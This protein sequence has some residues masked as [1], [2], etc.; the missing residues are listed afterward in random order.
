MK[1]SFL[2]QIVLVVLVAGMW[3]VG[4]APAV[5]LP[6]T[7]DD[8][9]AAKF[10]EQALQA[11]Q[12][13]NT[14]LRRQLLQEA[15]QQDPNHA[16]ARWHAGYVWMDQ[17][18][19]TLDEVARRWKGEPALAQYQQLRKQVLDG[20]LASHL[21]LAR[22]CQK[23]SLEAEA[24]AHWMNVL[25]QAPDNREAATALKLQPFHGVLVPADRLEEAKA[26]WSR[27][28]AEQRRWAKRRTE[29]L[30]RW[31]P[32]LRKWLAA[33][34]EKDSAGLRERIDDS[35]TALC[36]QEVVDASA[37]S[38]AL[39]EL[40]FTKI[41]QERGEAAREQLERVTLELVGVLRTIRTE[42]STVSLAR[43]AVDYP[44]E[45]VRQAATEALKERPQQ[46]VVPVLISGMQVP[47]EVSV[48]PAVYYADPYTWHFACQLRVFQDGPLA[49]FSE[50][51][52]QGVFA[53]R[54]GR[55]LDTS[56]FFARHV[57]RSLG[58]T[59]LAIRTA[60]AAEQRNLTV[61]Q[62]N[63]RIA[64]VLTGVT[65]T[66]GTSDPT[67]WADW[68]QQQ[69]LRYYELEQKTTG[70]DETKPQYWRY[71]HRAYYSDE[72]DRSRG[73]RAELER[74]RQS[75]PGTLGSCFLPD[76]P[77]WTLIGPV[78]IRQLKCGDRVLSQD[79]L[80]GQLAYKPV[81]EVT[82][83][84]PAEMIRLQVGS[85]TFLATRGHPF[86][87]VGA[88]W[89]MA[90]QLQQGDLLHTTGGPLP[91]AS[92][93]QVPPPGPAFE[94]AYNLIVDDFHTFFVGKERVLVH[95]N[96]LFIFDRAELPPVPGVAAK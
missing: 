56:G 81:L 15:L 4:V 93:E 50:V 54:E 20:S 7:A 23:H 49:S 82:T 67:Y 87:V 17:R 92:V 79:P 28:Q 95:D 94:Y 65:G 76:T 66:K 24:R 12:Q 78:P 69:Q 63:Q 88:G 37:A 47:V 68:W 51:Q 60:V 45:A 85:D 61:E 1:T 91:V 89:K 77:V 62:R 21:A 74:I 64:R 80:T 52:S 43:Y 22:W 58:I 30:S 59:Y 38:S 86:W 27:W 26:A 44:A 71:T 16:P 3:S 42:W 11:E 2:Q 29:W 72:V 31:K 14:A 53:Q 70:D 40:L 39:D 73:Y 8:S 55:P 33:A 83:R 25:R 75:Q 13:G 57:G 35:L 84:A 10:V 19:V 36:D 41:E 96:T 90:K 46:Q 5:E 34:R 18:W 48:V 32:Q 9:P 6:K